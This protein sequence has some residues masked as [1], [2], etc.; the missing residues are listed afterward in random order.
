MVWMVLAARHNLDGQKQYRTAVARQASRRAWGL[1]IKALAIAWIAWRNPAGSRASAAT[2]GAENAT[3]AGSAWYGGHRICSAAASLS[4]SVASRRKRV[5]GW[6][7]AFA[8]TTWL[9]VAGTIRGVGTARVRG[10]LREQVRE[11][12]AGRGDFDGVEGCDDDGG[13]GIQRCGAWGVAQC[14]LGSPDAR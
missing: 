1:A 4:R 11:T 12:G 5:S 10:R 9:T 3:R 6:R 14:D 2:S 8:E 13:H 7:H